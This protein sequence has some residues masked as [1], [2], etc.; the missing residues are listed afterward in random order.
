MSNG[1]SH[2]AIAKPII[3]GLMPSTVT[4]SGSVLRLHPVTATP[5]EANVMATSH[6]AGRP[7]RARHRPS[8]LW[9]ELSCG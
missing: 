6:R 3:M 8:I 5:P 1:A 7:A 9:D 4:H 2:R